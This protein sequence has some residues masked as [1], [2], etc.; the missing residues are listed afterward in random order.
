MEFQE[1]HIKQITGMIADL[2]WQ[3]K[4]GTNWSHERYDDGSYFYSCFEALDLELRRRKIDSK[5][6]HTTPT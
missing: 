5:P 4:D 1:R 3:T 2:G 6:E